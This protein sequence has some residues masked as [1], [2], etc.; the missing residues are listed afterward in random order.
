MLRARRE[1]YIYGYVQNECY[2]GT[3][4]HQHI[5]KKRRF[6]YRTLCRHPST[7]H[8]QNA[9]ALAA[10]LI[11]HFCHPFSLPLSVF[12]RVCDPLKW[13]HLIATMIT[14][15]H[16]KRPLTARTITLR[17]NHAQQQQRTSNNNNKKLTVERKMFANLPLV[18][19]QTAR[20]GRPEWWRCPAGQS[21]CSGPPSTGR[22]LLGRRAS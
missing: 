18:S 17:G 15:T 7:C 16:P 13:R 6:N 8:T 22:S 10:Y 4:V 21:R 14:Y 3:C 9:H 19:W 2:I 5:Q 20:Y 12:V 11:I 1:Q